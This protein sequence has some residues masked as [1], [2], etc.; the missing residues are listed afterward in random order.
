MSTD[1]APPKK[2]PKRWI[3][4]KADE[5]AIRN[6]ARFDA[7]KGEAVC[8]WLEHYCY[9]YEGELAKNPIALMPW[10]R[11][12]VM[13]LFGWVKYSTMFKR[14]IRRFRR[15]AIFLPKKSGKTPLNAAIGLYLLCGDGEQGQKVYLSARDGKQALIQFSHAEAMVNFSPPLKAVCEINKT[16]HRITHVPTLSWMS[17]VAGDNKESQEGLNGSVMVDELHVVSAELMAILKGAGISRSEPF[18]IAISTAGNNPDGYGKRQYDYGKHVNAGSKGYE[19]DGFFFECYEADQRI[20]VTDDNILELGKKANP[21]WG[22]T[23]PPD[24]FMQ[25]YRISKGSL[26]EYRNFLMYRLGRWQRA[27]NPWIPEDAWD[28]CQSPNWRPLYR[29]LKMLQA[30]G[31]FDVSQRNDITA[32]TLSFPVELMRLDDARRA[33]YAAMDGRIIQWTWLWLCEESAERISDKIEEFAL[34]VKSGFVKVTPGQTVNHDTVISDIC[35]LGRHFRIGDVGYDKMYAETL[36]QYVSRGLV[37]DGRTI[38]EGIG[39]RRVEFLQTFPSLALPT[40]NFEKAL[41]DKTLLVIE[42]PCLTW[43]ANHCE[44]RQDNHGN[45]KP[46]KPEGKDH[47]KIDGIMSSVMSLARCQAR[48]L[49]RP[50]IS[51]I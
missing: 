19:D 21:S 31:G 14:W 3:R 27:C 16:Y 32:F 29:L 15:A 28:A 51:A 18:Q 38:V 44:V 10:Q 42:N 9:L 33:R 47:R 48:P 22:Y 35:R 17:I 8:A 1:K 7:E 37:R 2:V 34:W 6:G 4:N 26:T 11:D 30:Y 25:D 46:E 45:R 43:M 24:E 41:L 49:T 5:L 39:C 12:I 50:H 20:V 13:R 40:T 36:M 23:V